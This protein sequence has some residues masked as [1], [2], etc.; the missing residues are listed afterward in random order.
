MR[1]TACSIYD[2]TRPFVSFK[3]ILRTMGAP[4]ADSVELVSFHSISKGQT[5]EVRPSLQIHADAAVR[6]TRRLL[7]DRQL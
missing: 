4:Y 6:T 7:R 3:R 5:G 1:L 2:K